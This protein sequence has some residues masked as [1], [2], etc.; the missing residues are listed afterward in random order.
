MAEPDVNTIS[1]A[2]INNIMMIGNSQNFFLVFR[3][4]HKSLKNS[5]LLLFSD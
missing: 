4:A 2:N 3:N 1:K 5:T